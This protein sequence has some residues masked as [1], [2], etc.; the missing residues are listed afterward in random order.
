MKLAVIGASGL[1]GAELVRR[2]RA[3]NIATAGAAR[4]VRG[5][6]TTAVDLSDRKS[7]AA[8]FE[9][10][11][12]THIAVAAA[13]P[14]VD[15]CEK[16][17]ARSHRENVETIE[18]VIAEA[19]SKIKIVFFSTDHVFDG[20]KATS[21]V[22]SDATNPLSVYA[23]HKLEVEQLLGARGN[24]LV[25][26]TAWVFGEELGKKNFVYRVAA[27][28]RAG[29]LLKV[30]EKQSGCPTWTGWLTE[31]T[32]SLL[33][34]DANGIVH[35]TGNQAFSKRDWAIEIADALSLAG[36]RVE[37]ASWTESGQIAPR[38]AHVALKSERHTYVQPPVRGLLAE[39]SI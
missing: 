35:V 10:E 30:P 4:T 24:S 18:N 15:G 31:T 34:D 20:K 5:E 3:Q 25:V 26:R 36:L 8:F 1:V 14:Y 28:A 13:W 19:G 11:S 29:E 22:E 21:Y 32:L 2:A 6:A 23:K 17:P 38:P 39:L 7:L 12:P 9:N 33:N 27:A 37:E 16:D